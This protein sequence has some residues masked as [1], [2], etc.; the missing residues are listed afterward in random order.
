[1]GTTRRKALSL[2]L[3]AVVFGCGGRAME[4][5][6]SAGSPSNSG[7]TGIPGAGASQR[8]SGGNPQ[9]GGATANGGGVGVDGNCLCDAVAGGAVGVGGTDAGGGSTT[10]NRDTSA[11]NI[12]PADVVCSVDSDCTTLTVPGCSCDA[13]I[14]VGVNTTSSAR[15]GAACVTPNDEPLD[16]PPILLLGEDCRLA[17]S[18]SQILSVCT[19][20]RCLTKSACE[21][22]H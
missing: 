12:T 16:C 19:G 2:S 11:C 15:C 20:G 21:D 8:A 7:E 6:G 9:V 22:C 17:G 5:T 4:Y 14:V 1:M 13:A 18:I 10:C 3:L